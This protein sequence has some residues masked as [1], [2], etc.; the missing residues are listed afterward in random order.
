[1][2]NIISKE[3]PTFSIHHRLVQLKQGD[4]AVELTKNQ[5]NAMTMLQEGKFEDNVY[6]ADIY[7][8][9]KITFKNNGFTIEAKTEASYD[10]VYVSP[11][12]FKYLIKYRDDN[13]PRIAWDRDFRR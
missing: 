9:N 13:R 5:I 4:N 2:E 12:A 11:R 6:V 10:S 3:F 8:H 7:P 1:M